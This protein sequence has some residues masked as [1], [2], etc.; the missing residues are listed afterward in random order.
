M[1]E[2]INNW[3]AKPVG[4]YF[5]GLAIFLQL[6]SPEIKKKYEAFFSE[7]KE[8]PGQFDV[9]LTMLVNKVSAI[10]AAVKHN[11]KA[12]EGIEL[13]L[14]ATG[15]D[16]ETL[17]LIESKNIEIANQKTKAAEK[18]AEVELLK[19]KLKLLKSDN[20]EITDENEELTDKISDLELE[21]GD[22][23]D[24]VSVYAEKLVVLEADIKALKAKRGLQIV[25]LAD[26]PDDVRKVWERNQE[27]TPLMASIHA[28]IGV[29]GLHHATRKKL[30]KQ[31]C[32]F[33][34]ERRANWD[35]IEDWSEGKETTDFKIEKPEFS[36]DPIVAGAQIARRIE[37][38]KEN[39]IRSKATLETAD[40]DVIK[41]NANKRIAAYELE[42][43]ELEAKI[44]PVE[45]EG[46]VE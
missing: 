22:A 46:D 14:K 28:Q 44:K 37:R 29:E 27:I 19:E 35:I 34:D 5:D 39:I 42:L 32:D 9:H 1:L 31:L 10:E 24:E 26:M 21:L 36:S 7:V 12:F 8:E 17:A 41:E 16:A 6:A 3:L 40:R 18:A 45:K 4:R 38:L 43:S 23:Q 2:I 33:D 15:P 25:A 11:P 13:I 30:V 20:V